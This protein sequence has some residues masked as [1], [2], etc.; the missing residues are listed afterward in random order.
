[1]PDLTQSGLTI[2]TPVA[3]DAPRFLAAV[4]T[5]RAL[6]HPWTSPPSDAEAFATF[7]DGIGE[8]RL[9]FLI[10][11]RD[12][13]VGL[14][15]ASEIVRGSFHSCYL[16]YYA[17]VPAAGRGLMVR[18]MSLV[19]DRLFDVHGLHRAEANIQPTN[20]RSVGLVHRLG[21]TK[22]GFSRDYL[23]I[24]GAWRDHERWALLSTDPRPGRPPDSTR[25]V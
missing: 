3:G 10:R 23:H 19:L 16:G 22:E 13:L 17:F 4:A 7:L 24:D 1:M 6:H 20:H 25:T 2:A 9:S 21:F 18:G 15:N 11:S 5:S 8:R 12:D 14:V